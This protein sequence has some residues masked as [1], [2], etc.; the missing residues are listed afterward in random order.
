[1]CYIVGGEL[2]IKAIKFYVSMLRKCS[3]VHLLNYFSLQNKIKLLYWCTGK[4]TNEHQR[5]PF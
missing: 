4:G 3:P 5:P 2:I 1:M